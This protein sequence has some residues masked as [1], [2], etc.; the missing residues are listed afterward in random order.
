MLLQKKKKERIMLSYFLTGVMCM[1]IYITQPGDPSVG[2]SEGR[3][4]VNVK[5]LKRENFDVDGLCVI[6]SRM[7]DFGEFIFNERVNVEILDE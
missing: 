2:I 5:G 6:H 3:I 4:E 1:M 7:N